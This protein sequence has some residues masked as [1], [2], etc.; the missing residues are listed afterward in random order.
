MLVFILKLLLYLLIALLFL[1]F[2]LSLCRVSLRIVYNG[3]LGVFAS[4]GV[5]KIDV[6]KLMTPK[7]KMPKKRS[8][9]NDLKASEKAKKRTK[10]RSAVKVT[11]SQNKVGVEKEQ[12]APTALLKIVLQVVKKFFGYLKV[13][14]CRVNAVIATDDV[15]KTAIV[16]A[17]ANS[18]L[19]AVYGA[20]KN[21]KNF[22]ICEKCYFVT[23]DYTSNRSRYDVEIV[24]S[25]FVWQVLLCAIK[26]MSLYLEE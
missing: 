5:I 8:L 23:A 7:T 22:D 6:M 26:G 17:A 12:K 25:I 1:F 14:L 10:T 3:N 18:V 15:A 2:L 24:F 19:G 20:V 13:K 16:Y 11:P 21:Q 9:Y 4:L